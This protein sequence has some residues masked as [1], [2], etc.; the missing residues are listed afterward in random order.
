MVYLRWWYIS[1]SD[2]QFSTGEEVAEIRQTAV[3]H[4]VL[5]SLNV[6][7][8]CLVEGVWVGSFVTG[9]IVGLLVGS[10]VRGACVGLLVGSFVTGA[11]FGLSEGSSVTGAF[12]GLLVGLLVLALAVDDDV[13][14][15]RE[16]RKPS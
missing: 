16:G 1:C 6:T 10:S 11:F 7:E 3:C 9:A 14:E 12:V 15:G 4:C 5:V 2:L 13:D 8:N